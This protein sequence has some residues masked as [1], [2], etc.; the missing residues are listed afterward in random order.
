MVRNQATDQICIEAWKRA[1]WC[2]GTAE[3]FLARSR[4]YRRDMNALSLVGIA[5]PLLV[6]ELF[7]LSGQPH[8]ICQK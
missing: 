7:L 2:F 1:I 5:V 8:L 3:I 4:R 6:V